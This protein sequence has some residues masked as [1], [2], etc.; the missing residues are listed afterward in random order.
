MA[1]ATTQYYG[2]DN[3]QGSPDPDF[4]KIQPGDPV[5]GANNLVWYHTRVLGGPD[6]FG[7]NNWIQAPPGAYSATGTPAGAIASPQANT[8]QPGQSGY[9]G[10]S[11]TGPQAYNTNPTSQAVTMDTLMSRLTQPTTIDT[12]DPAFRK[13]A[14]TYAAAS[15]RARR[16]AVSDAAEAAGPYGTG[17]LQGQQR[18]LTENAA[19]QQAGFEA[20]L[21]GREIQNKRDEVQ[22]ALTSMTGLLSQDQQNALQLQL[23]QL[24]AQL[25]QLGITSASDTAAA[26][27]ALKDKLGVGGLNVDLMQLLLNNQQFGD[28]LGFN[29]ANASNNN[30]LAWAQLLLG[31]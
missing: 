31:S 3:Y 7:G 2:K 6:N 20:D 16:N 19:Q 17:A 14:D 25:K 5:S 23:A 12:N 21:V 30:D 4:N 22:N 28:T 15:E 13:Q 18:M 1:N 29:V 9:Y 24:D 11:A 10:G 8:T 26:E 27:L